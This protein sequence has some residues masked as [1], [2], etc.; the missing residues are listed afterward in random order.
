MSSCE[1]EADIAHG[2]GG[3][4]AASC[5]HTEAPQT[6]LQFLPATP[7]TKPLC[8][9]VTEGAEGGGDGGGDGGGG[10]GDG[11]ASETTR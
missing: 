8:S 9:V 4:S 2:E 10:V 11:D 7:K 6:S 1:S 3:L 5:A